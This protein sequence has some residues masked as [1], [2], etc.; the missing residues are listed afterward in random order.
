MATDNFFE[1]PDFDP[2]YDH[3]KEETLP[4]TRLTVSPT[5]PS[6]FT[7]DISYLP[8]V[9][10]QG[11]CPSCVAWGTVYGMTTFMAA[12]QGGY[13][14]TTTAQQAS[15]AFIY[16]KVMQLK[17]ETANQCE[18]SN[19]SEYIKLL[20]QDDGTPS[21]ATAPYTAPSGTTECNYLWQEYQNG[22]PTIDTAFDVSSTTSI[23]TLDI[24]QV[25]Q[26]L[27]SGY[28]VAYGTKLYTDFGAYRG[29]PTP[30]V[31]NGVI[32]NNSN[33]KPVG[34]CMLIIG[35][36]NS[37]GTSGAFLIQNSWGTNW[38]AKGWVWM[39]YDTFTALA[40]GTGVYIPAT[41]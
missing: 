32:R 15:P 20:G 40:Q 41:T 27:S 19:L 33:G 38:G 25:Q 36:D 22:N 31:G 29:S 35:Y 14:P 37:V 17:K 1:A 26:A 16:I 28:P 8:P 30:Y 12:A 4:I 39:A 23:S 9:G 3:T 5:L 10:N 34:H 18:G 21:M 24:T 11:A 7:V 13:S 2:G 6:S